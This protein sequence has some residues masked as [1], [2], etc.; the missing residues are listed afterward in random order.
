MGLTAVKQGDCHNRSLYRAAMRMFGK[1][2]LA[3]K[4]A[5]V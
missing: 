2:S 3:K 5:G 4:A 1:W